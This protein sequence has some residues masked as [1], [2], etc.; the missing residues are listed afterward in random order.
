MPDAIALV[1]RYLDGANVEC[2][3]DTAVAAMAPAAWATTLC[4]AVAIAR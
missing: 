4:F 1:D 2:L 3:A